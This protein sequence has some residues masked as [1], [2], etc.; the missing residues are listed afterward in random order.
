[1]RILVLLNP[2]NKRGTKAEVYRTE[3]VFSQRRIY[4]A[5]KWSLYENHE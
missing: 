2:T 1:M 4:S 5:S 3:E